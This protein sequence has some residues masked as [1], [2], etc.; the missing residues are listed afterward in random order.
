MRSH[1]LG[2]RSEDL[3]CRYL[4]DR[5]W[6]ILQRNFRAGHREID[7][8]VRNGETTAFVEVK[9]RSS[10]D[11]LLALS[12]PKQ[13]EIVKAARAWLADNAGPGYEYR[14]DA[15]IIDWRGSRPSIEHIPNAWLVF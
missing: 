15:I 9:A 5:G 6:T 14:F 3:A 1:D 11:P 10:S 4:Q 12:R 7:I 13:R 8:V 2:R